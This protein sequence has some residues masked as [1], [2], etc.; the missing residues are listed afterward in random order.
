MNW[1]RF[2][3]FLAAA[4][5]TLKSHDEFSPCPKCKSRR[6]GVMAGP[7]GIAIYCIDCKLF[8]PIRPTGTAAAVAWDKRDY[9]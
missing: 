8:G 3:R 2:R 7:D 6:S 5:A 1:T 9:P 4:R